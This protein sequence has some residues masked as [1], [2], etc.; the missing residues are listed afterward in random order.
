[1]TLSGRKGNAL[2]KDW[3]PENPELY[4]DEQK[5]RV[6]PEI[7][8]VS[9]A[10]EPSFHRGLRPGTTSQSVLQ[11]TS[12]ERPETRLDSHALFPCPKEKN[13]VETPF[14]KDLMYAG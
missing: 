1:M 3:T 14:N 11:P 13:P 7:S 4:S 5:T 9:R 6:F 10:L 2:T 12:G 8:R